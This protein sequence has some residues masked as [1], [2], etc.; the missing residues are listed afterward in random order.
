MKKAMT[1]HEMRK[2]EERI[3]NYWA[4]LIVEN[5]ALAPKRPFIVL[6]KLRTPKKRRK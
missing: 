1:L 3:K 4:S 5:I 2:A 6:K